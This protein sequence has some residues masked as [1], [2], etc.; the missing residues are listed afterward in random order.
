[1]RGWET[2]PSV[3]IMKKVAIFIILIMVC[4]I[5]GAYPNLSL[6]QY[7]YDILRNMGIYLMQYKDIDMA[8]QIIL[9]WMLLLFAGIFTAKSKWLQTYFLWVWLCFLMINNP[10]SFVRFMFILG[11][12]ILYQIASERL[13]DKYIKWIYVAIAFIGLIHI[14]LMSWQTIGVNIFYSG[15]QNLPFG[16]YGNTNNTGMLIAICSAVLFRK[17]WIILFIPFL[18]GLCLSQALLAIVATGC[19]VLVWF[20]LKG[21]KKALVGV[22][23]AVLLLVSGYTYKY[24]G[25]NN[26]KNRV[27]NAKGENRVVH[28]KKIYKEIMKSPIKGYGLGHFPYIYKWMDKEIYKDQDNTTFL[29]PHNDTLG[30]AYNQGLVGLLLFLGFV[31]SVILKYMKKRTE[32]G[33]IALVGFVISIVC[34]M[35]YSIMSTTMIL[36]TAIFLII[37]N[38]QTEERAC[39]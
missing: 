8:K 22:S 1:M 28:F 16:V 36:I 17:W 26:V 21:S 32:L 39:E 14:A 24:E 27:F 6:S 5:L 10:V 33:D 15:H 29:K 25:F 12:L 31:F 35:G 23:V 7:N 11:F 37:I 9:L 34:S 2:C 4:S 38:N 30:I 13:T 3:S 20:Y 18:Y 19:G